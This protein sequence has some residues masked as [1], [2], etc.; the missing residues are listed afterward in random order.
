MA[1]TRKE[2][3]IE[4]R[5]I[6]MK[7]KHK[8]KSFSTIAQIINRTENSGTV[9]NRQRI[10]RPSKM[11]N[12]A[13]RGVL[14]E[15]RKNPKLSAPKLAAIQKI[16]K[17]DITG[18]ESLKRVIIEEWH[19]IPSTV[20]CNLV[21][22]MPRRLEAVLQAKGGPTRNYC[23]KENDPTAKDEVQLE[24]FFWT[25][26]GD[27][28]PDFV[29]NV[30]TGI[31][32]GN[33]VI[34][35]TETVVATVYV[36]EKN[37]TDSSLTPLCVDCK[38]D[39]KPPLNV[40]TTDRRYWL[41]TVISGYVKPQDHTSLENKLANLYRVAFA[42]QQSKHLGLSNGGLDTRKSDFFNRYKREI[43]NESLQNQ[44][45]LQQS[46]NNGIPSTVLTIQANN[47]NF[48]NS[49][50]GPFHMGKQISIASAIPSYKSTEKFDI[51]DITELHTIPPLDISNKTLDEVQKKDATGYDMK[52]TSLDSSNPM[53]SEYD[54]RVALHNVTL[55]SED[56]II[57]WT[58][59][60]HLK[61][62][63]TEDEDEINIKRESRPFANQTEIIYT[64][65]VN[66]KPVLAT[67]AAEDMRLVGENE[68]AL[69][70]GK[71]VFMKAEPYLKEPQATPLIPATKAM[72]S[73][74]FFT[75]IQTN[76][77]LVTITS[78]CVMLI[79]LL[80]LALLLMTRAKRE[81]S[82]EVKRL[83]SRSGLL[84]ADETQRSHGM[85]STRTD[86]GG[87]LS[88]ISRLDGEYTG[89]GVQNYGFEHETS[90][91]KD[92]DR[93]RPHISFPLPPN[94]ESRPSSSST[95]NTSDSS[96]YCPVNRPNID[97]QHMLDEKAAK[98]F[99]KKKKKSHHH[100]HHHYKKNEPVYTS[101][102]S[103]RKRD[104]KSKASKNRRRYLSDN[105]VGSM[106]EADTN[107]SA[108]TSVSN[109]SSSD[110]FKPDY[111][112]FEHNETYNLHNNYHRNK[113]LQNRVF[114][115]THYDTV[116]EEP[117]S[118]TEAINRELIRALQPDGKS[119]E[120]D[121]IGSFLSMASVKN[122]PKSTLPEPLNR[123]LEP[124]S[125]TYYDHFDD[126]TVRA[127]KQT[128]RVRTVATIEK[129]PLDKDNKPLQVAIAS[130]SDNPDPGVVGPIVWEIHKKKMSKNESLDSPLRDP[131]ATR[132]RFEGLL[133]DAI[134]LYDDIPSHH[135]GTLGKNTQT[136]NPSKEN[137]GKSAIVSSVT[138]RPHK[139]NQEP[140]PLT[141]DRYQPSMSNQSTQP[142][143]PTVG[144]WSSGATSPHPTIVRPL[145]AGPF[146]RPE[147]PQ[148]DVT[149]VLVSQNTEK[150]QI[151]AAP[152]I[153]AIQNELQKFKRDNSQ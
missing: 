125:V 48:N 57:N 95:A 25:G 36:N 30:H 58:D 150:S 76:P 117:M 71:E 115:D 50:F 81:R 60:E 14:Q 21:Q 85:E 83:S 40:S 70:M 144:A 13:K 12:R 1:K 86:E 7:L 112:N 35:K 118:P 94:G 96:V 99:D 27:G 89:D 109:D 80:L 97:L 52:T 42:R 73:P 38:N 143:S 62:D 65:Y 28:P 107:S 146:H 138:N 64:V 147:P 6:I 67:T 22:S 72:Q 54:V 11:D 17:H 31:S 15:L 55:L 75:Y 66:G 63:D 102:D 123:V 5:E 78:I 131:A 8:G 130:Q 148:V 88:T 91:R 137:R 34:V 44:Q 46:D 92:G 132:N 43:R 74:N 128:D 61:N 153:E 49:P 114:T 105:R 127:L 103:D 124:V 104:K 45:Q 122:F 145:S 16:R 120:N 101:V 68:V 108:E 37:D 111:E 134:Q 24:D 140:R 90:R 59:S 53:F 10:G 69:V 26:S 113:V 82:A 136:R 98:L 110:R 29:K 20:T 41:L 135:P 84:A 116:H 39:G 18:K 119:S 141:A 126:G 151:S 149:R 152:L 142:P 51:G 121:S 23:E 3:T 106:D 100:H 56:E 139:P 133:E 2:T 19:K 93:N 4:E 9:E 32:K 47:K 129:V 77:I 79:L 87:G 33:N